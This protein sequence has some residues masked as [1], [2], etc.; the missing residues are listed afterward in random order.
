LTA[1]AGNSPQIRTISPSIP[2]DL[3][4]CPQRPDSPSKA[5][6]QRDVALFVLDLAA[7]HDGCRAQLRRLHE[8]LDHL[9]AETAP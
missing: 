2:A 4:Y 5:A 9:T 6:T 8:L 3:F 1:C 7:A